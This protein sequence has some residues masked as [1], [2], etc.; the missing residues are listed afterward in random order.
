MLFELHCHSWYSKGTKVPWEC[1]SSPKDIVKRA[2]RLGL[3][4]VAITDH[5]TTKCWEEAKEEAKRLGLLFIPGIEL[6]TSGGHLIALGINEGIENHLGL[7]ETIERIHEQGGL[8]VAP[9][10]FDLKGDGI[11]NGIKRADVVEVFNSMNLDKLSNK[12]AEKKANELG[13]PMVAGSDAH[14]LEMIGYAVNISN[15][16]DLD[17]L[18]KEIKK[19]G[20]MFRTRY[21]PIKNLVEW[22]RERFIRSYVDVLNY[23]NGNYVYPKAVVARTLLNRFVRSRNVTW[24]AL[25]HLGV[26]VSRI[27]SRFKL[28]G[29]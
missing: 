24:N 17:S 27:Y 14:S 7:E 11:K 19:Q 21:L 1:M 4:G 2:K 13:K 28:S 23:V 12:I 26:G 18:L 5:K 29:Y 20:L 10:P 9:H 8:A 25:A 22:Y 3:S 15:S 6:Q 16:S